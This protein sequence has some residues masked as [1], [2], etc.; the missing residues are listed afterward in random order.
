MALEALKEGHRRALD[1]IAALE[2]AVASLQ[3]DPAQ[4]VAWLRQS[5]SSLTG[6]PE[7]H[8]RQEEEGL[9]LFLAQV[10]GEGPLRAMVEEHQGYWKAVEAL[11]EALAI[12]DMDEADL[13]RLE[14][15][16]VGVA[17][18]LRS[19]IHKEETA[20]FPLAESRLTPQQLE[21]V[22]QE[23]AAIARMG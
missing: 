11:R 10:T 16:V 13:A 4:S 17:T 3:R 5:L 23:M 14:R 18:R 1:V 22:D 21:E 9:F 6:E 15:I 19:H 20:Y 7:R 2:A 12:P 8:F